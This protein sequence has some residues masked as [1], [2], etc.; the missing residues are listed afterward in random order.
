MLSVSMTSSSIRKH[1]R[2]GSRSPRQNM[3]GKSIHVIDL[4]IHM[5]PRHRRIP[6]EH[7]MHRSRTSTAGRQY[8]SPWSHA[9]LARFNQHSARSVI[10]LSDPHSP[11][12]LALR[13]TLT[14]EFPLSEA[15]GASPGFGCF[16]GWCVW[17]A[18]SIACVQIRDLIRER[19]VHLRE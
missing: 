18:E 7:S 6:N 14:F 11:L 3:G 4:D 10:R 5:A 19:Q 17:C 13:S 9:M 1:I 2:L 8:L 12:W 15:A 16:R